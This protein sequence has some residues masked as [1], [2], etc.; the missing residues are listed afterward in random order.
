MKRLLNMVA[1]STLYQVLEG[2]V[3]DGRNVGTIYVTMGVGST[4]SMQYVNSQDLETIPLMCGHLVFVSRFCV[5]VKCQKF[6]FTLVHK[7]KLSLV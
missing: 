2:Q 4:S 7:T 5:C 1:W 6:K 3:G